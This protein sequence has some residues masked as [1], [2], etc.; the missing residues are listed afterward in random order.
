LAIV[1]NESSWL[2]SQMGELGYLKNQT[3]TI[4][5]DN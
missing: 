1:V 2:S 5:Y 4:Y 3:I